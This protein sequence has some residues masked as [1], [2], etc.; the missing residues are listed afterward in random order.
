MVVLLMMGCRADCSAEVTTQTHQATVRWAHDTPGGTATFSH[1]G[2]TSRSAEVV[3]EEGVLTAVLRGLPALSAVDFTVEGVDGKTCTGTLTTENLPP[4]L[5][6]ITASGEREEGLL[7]ITVMGESSAVG[8]ID[9]LGQW[10]WHH[11]GGTDALVSDAHLDGQ[12][13]LFNRY[14]KERIEDI[15]EVRRVGL[16]G[17]EGAAVRTPWGHHVFELLPDGTLAYPA[18]DV[19]TWTAEDGEDYEVVG[20]RIMEISPAGVEREVF[21][22]WDYATPDPSTD[23]GFYA[24]GYD[25]SHANSL[26][27]DRDRDSYLLS[28]GHL[29]EIYEVDRDGA[30][31]AQHVSEG[32]WSFQHDVNRTSAGTLLMISHDEDATSAVEFTEDLEPVWSY[33]GPVSGFLGQARRLESGNTL[34]N[35]GGKG[36]LQEVTP[37]GE[38]L[39]RVETSLGWWFGNVS[40]IDEPI[41]DSGV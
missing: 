41:W 27:H 1:L 39:W 23:D 5:P 12:D 2:A 17:V 25:W 20:D 8:I 7:L 4:E 37:A 10:R 11:L 18:L 21:T 40:W 14:D 19:R 34:V 16:D 6:T 31:L 32:R 22:I 35:F 33:S 30:V 3:A 13:V 38:V 9:Q 28:L 24:L 29:E 36:L 15:A 26:Q